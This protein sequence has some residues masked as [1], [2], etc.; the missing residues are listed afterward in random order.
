M[1]I[2]ITDCATTTVA[3]AVSYAWPVATLMFRQSSRSVLGHESK[4]NQRE[5]GLQV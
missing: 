2:S 5:R 4:H 1:N 3:A